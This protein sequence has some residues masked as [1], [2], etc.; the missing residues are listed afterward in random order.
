MKVINALA[1]C[2]ILQ[3]QQQLANRLYSFVNIRVGK[4][5]IIVKSTLAYHTIDNISN[6]VLIA[7]SCL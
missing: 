7:Y 1:Y 2:A 3:Q 4:M 6:N 5:S